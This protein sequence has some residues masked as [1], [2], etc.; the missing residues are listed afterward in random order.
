MAANTRLHYALRI[1]WLLSRGG[2]VTVNDMHEYFEAQI[3]KRSLQRILKTLSE[4][5]FPITSETGPHNEQFYS[6]ERPFGHIPTKLNVDEVLAALLLSQ[7]AG[8]FGG[9]RIGEDI[10]A[11]FTKLEQLLP[12][13][14]VNV[15]EP[16]GS[17]HYLYM[18]QAGTADI[19]TGGMLQT[20]F[21]AMLTGHVCRVQYRERSFRLHPYS[22]LL[23]NGV[24]YLVG[25]QPKHRHIIFLVMGRM[26]AVEILEQKF[27]RDSNFRLEQHF[28]ENFGI[29]AE[30]PTDVR[31]RFDATVRPSIEQRHWHHSQRFEES[32]DGGVILTMHVGPSLELDAWIL[33]WGAH[34]EVL[35]PAT[36]R[37]RIRDTARAMV[38]K[39]TDRR[40]G[41]R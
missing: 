20:V 36:L 37:K 8:V 22:L 41:R 9:T 3:E 19:D 35:E 13:D 27:T 26:R 11:V 15:Q 32:G 18:R 7:F 39:H 5:D 23:Y 14:M 21:E 17:G 24:L 38:A 29:W 33:R 10:K 25:Y 30:A 34:A 28:K 1:L 31:I 40:P 2:K 16:F 4:A 6:I 12:P